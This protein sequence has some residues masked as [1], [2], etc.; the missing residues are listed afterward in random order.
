MKKEISIKRIVHDKANRI[1]VETDM[2]GKTITIGRGIKRR[3]LD[4][5]EAE[6]LHFLLKRQLDRLNGSYSKEANKEKEEFLFRPKCGKAEM[7]TSN[8]CTNCGFRLRSTTIGEVPRVKKENEEEKTVQGKEQFLSSEE[9]KFEKI[10]GGIF[11]TPR[12]I[13]VPI[14]DRKICI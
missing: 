2:L 4:Q 14:E 3:R 10:H 7:D 8:F 6:R 13:E 5:W 12:P 11:K 9:E 1:Y